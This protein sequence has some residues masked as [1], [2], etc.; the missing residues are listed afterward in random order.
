MKIAM[1]NCNKIEQVS[2]CNCVNLKTAD[3]FR[4]ALLGI[5]LLLAFN[6]IVAVCKW[7]TVDWVL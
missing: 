3:L 7:K 5:D 1:I 4:L 6:A 2:Y